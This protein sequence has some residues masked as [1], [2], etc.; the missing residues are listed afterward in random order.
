M[1]KMNNDD[2]NPKAW[3]EFGKVIHS[4]I[5]TPNYARQVLLPVCCVSAPRIPPQR[6][7]P[8]SHPP[9]NL[10]VSY[11]DSDK[12]NQGAHILLS[13]ERWKTCLVTDLSAP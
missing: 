7:D 6:A 9:G 13:K 2:S 1:N 11:S 12:R 3:A 8:T 10:S 4:D 5:Q